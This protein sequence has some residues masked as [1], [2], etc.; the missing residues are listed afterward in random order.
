MSLGKQFVF[1]SLA[2]AMAMP[3]VGGSVPAQE[4]YLLLY[5][6]LGGHVYME[7]SDDGASWT[8]APTPFRSIG[9][10]GGAAAEGPR[11]LLAWVDP[12]R[13]I[14]FVDFNL[15]TSPILDVVNT[16][17]INEFASSAPSVVHGSQVGDWVFAFQ[18][19]TGQLRLAVH[20]ADGQGSRFRS[21]DMTDIATNTERPELARVDNT[22][23]LAWIDQQVL[24]VVQYVIGQIDQDNNIAWDTPRELQLAPGGLGARSLSLTDDGTDV[25]LAV[26]R[27]P[28]PAPITA[29]DPQ[30]RKFVEIY[31]LVNDDWEFMRRRGIHAAAGD[32][33][34]RG[35]SAR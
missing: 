29:D 5:E 4:R 8:L 18:D 2:A 30:G 27:S 1:A 31:R 21:I 3:F 35:G 19:V 20:D 26:S 16:G 12:Q 17:F 13:L 10:V 22:L 24:N 34:Q 33:S 25:Y 11:R 28:L 14:Q 7:E 32:G 23:V 9:G 6:G 15:P